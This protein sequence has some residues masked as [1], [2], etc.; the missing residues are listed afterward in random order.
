M[1]IGTPLSE[2]SIL[3]LLGGILV[4]VALLLRFAVRRLIKLPTTG[5]KVERR[6]PEGTPVE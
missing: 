5:P 1:D 2:A 6:N 3:L 4:S